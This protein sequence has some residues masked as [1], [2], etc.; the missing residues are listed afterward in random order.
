MSRHDLEKVF[1]S[2]L[3][4]EAL[5]QLSHIQK[6]A[7]RILT[8]EHIKPILKSLRWLPVSK[9]LHGLR[10]GRRITLLIPFGKF[11]FFTPF[12]FFFFYTHR[13]EIQT[14]RHATGGEMVE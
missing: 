12:L 9:S 6:A 3:P 7:A 1:I 8:P 4:K 5:R 13:P 14:H 11:S 10:R 2:S